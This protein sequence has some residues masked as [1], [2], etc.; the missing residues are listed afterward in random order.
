M[1]EYTEQ[2]LI[3]ALRKAD[4]AGDTAAARAIAQ[5]IKAMR[6]PATTPPAP[7]PA[8]PAP[9]PTEGMSGFDKFSAGVGKSFADT[10]RGLKQAGTEAV[11]F[12]AGGGVAS[13]V[14]IA[15]R[16]V[17]GRESNRYDNPVTRATGRSLDRQQADIDR[18]KTL[19][20]P[21]M[22]TGAGGAG[23]L[24]GYAAQLLGPGAAVR[25]T[26]AARAFL[27]TTVAGNAAQ[28]GLLGLM[29]PVASGDSRVENGGL[30]ALFG[31][32]GAA[33][34]KG[35]GMAAGRAKTAVP[36]AVR[37]V[38]EAAKARGITL[39]PGQLSDSRFLK[40]TQSMLR[41]VPF[42]G[43]QG[44]Y[45]AQVGDFNRAL[46]KTIGEDAPAITNEVYAAAKKRQGDKFTELTARNALK[47]DDAL[48]RNLSNIADSAKIS[49]TVSQEVE[50]AI[51]ALYSRATTGP[52][53]V[54]IPGEAYQSFDSEIGQ[55]VKN[56]GPVAHFL[57][58]VRS[59]VRKAMDDSISPEDA[60]AWRKLRTEYGNRKTLTALASKSP[61]GLIQ[62]AQV[63]GAVTSSKAG[64]EAMASGARGEL[65]TLAKI[66][67]RIKEPPSSGTAE[68]SVVGA[69]LGGGAMIDPVTGGLTAAA[70]NLLS[71]GLDSQALARLMM[72]EN[73]G[74]TR[75][76]AAQIIQRAANPAGA[77]YS[78]QQQVG[79]PATSG[80][81]AFLLRQ[82]AP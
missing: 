26:A 34:A 14:G 8:E 78:A 72:R 44:R 82:G 32:G 63:M 50:S 30:G 59:A 5:R 75:Q 69:M 55:I 4:A 11:D 37:D 70:L 51:D 23:N 1:A 46:T 12:V 41:S 66:G 81:P 54:V 62:P 47:V 22:D 39:S 24:A 25:G 10:Y 60:A 58:S 7:Q 61:D 52:K 33:V 21:L 20:A 48:L 43:A 68:R 67:Q 73:P 74:M 17:R 64:K 15:D 9:D 56:G 2:Q 45:S 3:G 6:Q 29:Q 38:Y 40:W 80:L 53:G 77:S 19:D 13:P 36:E 71:R 49:P 18:A 65:G 28:G 57:G 27:P 31:A 42:T 35:V 16:L 76:V 79:A